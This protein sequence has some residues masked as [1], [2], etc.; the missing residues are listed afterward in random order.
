MMSL[1]SPECFI[2]DE[3]CQPVISCLDWWIHVVYQTLMHGE[4]LMLLSA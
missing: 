3:C 1:G 2:F 4:A